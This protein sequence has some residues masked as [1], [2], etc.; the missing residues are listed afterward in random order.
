MRLLRFK[1]NKE[2]S[3]LELME[4]IQMGNESFL[5]TLYDKCRSSINHYVINNK[6]TEDEAEDIV[7][8]TVILAWEKIIR[9]ELVLKSNTKLSTYLMG[10]A[11]NKWYEALRAKGKM[12]PIPEDYEEA[13]EENLEE[14]KFILLSELIN[15][16]DD[17]CREILTQ[18]YWLKKK[19]EE[20]KIQSVPTTAALK[21]KSSR[22]HVKLKELHAAN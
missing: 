17:I 14:E 3:D 11:R 1:S 18:K 15:K 10:I 16:L 5:D 9:K 7:Q 19:F 13:E 2:I 20:I 8:D 22:C 21:M 12:A 6:G 4:G